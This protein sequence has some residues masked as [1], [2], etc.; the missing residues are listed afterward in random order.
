[1][2]YIFRKFLNI[3]MSSTISGLNDCLRF[4]KTRS[5]ELKKRY[6]MAELAGTPNKDFASKE[7][8]GKIKA[9]LAHHSNNKSSFEDKIF[10]FM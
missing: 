7:S 5:V 1:M 10:E 6:E 4:C 9:C 2:H 8:C 3:R